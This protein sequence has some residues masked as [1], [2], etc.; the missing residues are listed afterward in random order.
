M[1]TIIAGSR[2][3]LK[4]EV[5]LHV[6]LNIPW[7]ITE[8]VSGTARGVDQLGEKWAKEF[9]ITVKKFPAD[10]NTWG[11]SAGYKRNREMAMYADALVSLWDGESKGTKHMRD[12]AEKYDLKIFRVRVNMP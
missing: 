6:M 5:L 7:Q 10:W 9:N 1:K 4:Y 2:T 11:R 8:V 3:I 12:L